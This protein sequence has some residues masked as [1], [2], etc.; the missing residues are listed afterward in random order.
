M[1]DIRMV[2]GVGINDSDGLTARSFRVDG[3][4][5]TVWRCP[6]YATWIDMLRRCY[7]P[8]VQVIQASYV[9]CTVDP[10]WHR[11]SEFKKWMIGK[12]WEGND[13]DKDILIPGNRVYSSRA[14]I[15]ISSS[16]NKFLISGSSRRGEWPI[17]VH[18]A[19]RRS[20]FASQCSNPF[21]GK[22]DNLGY[23]SCPDAAHEAWRKRKHQHALRYADMQDDPRV[24]DALRVR[25]LS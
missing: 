11:F 16:L 14:C 24:A 3:R 1:T 17:G 5:V 20:R 19:G 15:F 10:E 25:F 23:F 2:F 18:W 13:L 22:K 7:S 9:G 8:R 12:D 6:F 4:Q 21:T